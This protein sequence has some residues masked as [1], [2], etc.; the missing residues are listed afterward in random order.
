MAQPG[1][2]AIGRQDP[3]GERGADDPRLA[4]IYR[5]AVRGLTHQQ[6]VVESLNSRAGN[7][8]FAAAFATSL[9][10]TRAL[11]DGLGLWEWAAVTLLFA[12]GAL[13]VFT[14]WPVQ[15]YTFRFDPE[16]LLL[17]YVD[18]DEPA[19]MSALHRSLALRIKQ[20]MAGNWRVITRIRVALQIALVCL[21]LEI[22]AWLAAIAQVGRP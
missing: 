16:D 10:G 8:I 21:L 9:L 20:D 1:G 7:L 5:E 15:S 14:L 19:T 2:P 3:E 17:R 18:G 11:S 6:G 13:V 4:L 22:L 12:L